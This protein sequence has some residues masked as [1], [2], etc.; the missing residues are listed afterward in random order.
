MRYLS[1]DFYRGLTIALMLVVNTPGT[2]AHVYAPLLHAEWHGCTLTDL[3]FPSFLFIVGV[4]MWFSFSKYTGA[5]RFFLLRKALRRA[6]LLVGVGLVLSWYPFW[7]KSLSDLRLMG[8]LQRIGLCYGLAS[9]LVL[10]LPSRWL[11]AVAVALLF[12]YWGAL[13]WSALPGTDSFSLEHNLVRRIDLAVLGERHLWKGKGIAFDPE[14]LLSTFPAVVTVLLGWWSGEQIR[15]AGE[16]WWRAAGRLAL[17]GAILVV[18]GLWWHSTFPINKSL[19]T[20]SFVLYT[21]GLSMAALAL[22]VWL[23]DGLRWRRGVYFFLVFGANPLFAFVFSGLV[24]K[25]L[26]HLRWTA[27]GGNINAY[28]WLY[29]RF[30]APIEPYK[31]GSLLFAL[32]FLLLCWGLCWLLYRRGIYIKI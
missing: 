7:N 1:V 26:L 23:I 18:L 32:A 14:G 27:E 4:S 22:S 17:V 12:G 31:I 15:R 9:L 3:V 16:E 2:W 13:E 19:W 21:G 8:V 11:W 20:S 5:D 25:T 28:R 30:F 6:A 10:Y 29:E 24:V